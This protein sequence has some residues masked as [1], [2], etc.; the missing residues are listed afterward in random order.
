M[1]SQETVEDGLIDG[2]VLLLHVLEDG[3]GPGDIAL[4]AVEADTV[5]VGHT[6]GE[7]VLLLQLRQELRDVHFVIIFN[8]NLVKDY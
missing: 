5:L 4:L 8:I 1:G 2:E 3:G 6:V 7:D